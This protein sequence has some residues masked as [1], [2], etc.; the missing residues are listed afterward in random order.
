[1]QVIDKALDVWGLQLLPY[2]SQNPISQQARQDPTYVIT[3]LFMSSLVFYII[4]D[5]HAVI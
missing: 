3:E 2:N 1:M 4:N 5:L